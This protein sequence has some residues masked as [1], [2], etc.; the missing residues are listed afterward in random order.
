[1]PAAGIEGLVVKGAAQAYEGGQRQWLKVKHRD[2]L[3]VVCGAVIG[4][5]AQPAAIVAGLPI[6]GALRIVG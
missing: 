6:G 1:M 3:D 5:R 4:S 2:V